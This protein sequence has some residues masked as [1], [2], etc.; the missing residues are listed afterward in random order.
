MIT[1]EIKTSLTPEQERRFEQHVLRAIERAE[2]LFQWTEPSIEK[3]NRRRFIRVIGHGV[4]ES[5]T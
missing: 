2:N 1:I 5:E 4:T 3:T